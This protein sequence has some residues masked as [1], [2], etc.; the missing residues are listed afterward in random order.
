MTVKRLNLTVILFNYA[1]ALPLFSAEYT[2]GI[3]CTFSTSL[4]QNFCP[5]GFEA[6]EYGC[7]VSCVCAVKGIFES[8]IAF[9]PNTLSSLLAVWFLC[10]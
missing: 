1:P 2:S 6:D 7:P 4:C 5:L 9:N 3:E 10:N 8:D